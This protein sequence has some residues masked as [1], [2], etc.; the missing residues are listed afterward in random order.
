MTKCGAFDP[1]TR[2][3]CGEGESCF[4]EDLEQAHSYDID[5]NFDD[6]IDGGGCAGIPMWSQDTHIGTFGEDRDL[7]LAG[8][9]EGNGIYSHGTYDDTTCNE[10]SEDYL[11]GTSTS[12]CEEKDEEE[13]EEEN[14]FAASDASIIDA[15]PADL[16]PVGLIRTY[17]GDAIGGT[18]VV[19]F[20][21]EERNG[22][23]TSISKKSS[24]ISVVGVDNSDDEVTAATELNVTQDSYALEGGSDGHGDGDGAGIEVSIE[25]SDDTLEKSLEKLVVADIPHNYNT[26]AKKVPEQAERKI[27]TRRTKPTEQL[28]NADETEWNTM[29]SDFLLYMHYEKHGRGAIPPT[30]RTKHKMLRRW[31]DKQRE[32]FAKGE[33]NPDQTAKWN[34]IEA[35]KVE[36]RGSF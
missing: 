13:K 17:K 23:A 15:S 14:S 24:K 10:G 12:N 31:V 36:S 4:E 3:F 8:T 6:D 7:T 32:A 34:A 18:E 11:S 21:E 27:P 2:I 16:P 25:A 9:E 20:N 1:F 28:I 35:P 30:F 5:L 33:L 22:D 26:C 29:Y 19:D